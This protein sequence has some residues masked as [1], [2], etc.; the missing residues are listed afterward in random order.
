M[1]ASI[2]IGECSPCQIVDTWRSEEK[3]IVK[4]FEECVDTWRDTKFF[5]LGM[6]DIL[7]RAKVY[8]LYLD[9]FISK[10]MI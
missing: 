7:R 4:K 1:M 9:S 3:F 5:P 2:E 8:N 10:M 6:L